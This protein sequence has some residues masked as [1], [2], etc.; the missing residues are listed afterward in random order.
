M[1][2]HK[3]VQRVDQERCSHD[4]QQA[5]ERARKAYLGEDRRASAAVAWNRCAI[6]KDEP[7]AL[8][9]V[10]LRDGCE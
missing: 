1:A 10:F 7:P 3:L 6:A 9:A 2:S 5:R 4:S 8:T